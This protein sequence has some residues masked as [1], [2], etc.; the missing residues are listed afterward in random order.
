M[1]ISRVALLL[2]F[3]IDS[4]LEFQIMRVLHFIKWN[5]IAKRQ[6]SVLAFSNRPW[7]SS[8]LGNGLLS[9]ISQI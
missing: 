7:N 6:K 4:E 1:H 2:G 5:E 9:A 3:P 8:L